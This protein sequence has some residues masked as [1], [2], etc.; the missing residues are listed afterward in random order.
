LR[1]VMHACVSPFFFW[2]HGRSPS[3]SNLHALNFNCSRSWMQIL[4]SSTCRPG[5]ESSPLH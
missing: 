5:C 4:G 2:L 3:T 1:W